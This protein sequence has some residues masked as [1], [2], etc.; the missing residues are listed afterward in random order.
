VNE[1][2]SI[3]RASS[4]LSHA[5][6]ASW[7]ATLVRVRGPAYRHVGARLL[8]ARE[9]VI[10]GSLSAG[11]IEAELVRTG[12]WH[13]AAGA[14]LRSFEAETPDDAEPKRM[15]S[16][17]GG[18]V[19]ALIEPNT[20]ACAE[21]LEFIQGAQANQESV[22]MATVIK[23][24]S[25]LGRLGAR[26]V[27]SANASVSSGSALELESELGMLTRLALAAPASKPRSLRRGAF[28]LLLEVL[29][30]APHLFVF[31]AGP[32]VV[33]VVAL[34]HHLGWQVTVVS[35]HDRPSA[36]ERFVKLCRYGVFSLESALS[37]LDRSARPLALV[38]SHDYEDDRDALGALLESRVRYLGVLGPL[39]RTQRLIY[40]LESAGCRHALGAI[41]R[42]HAPVGLSIGA[43]TP[44]EIA[45]SI[46]AE[47]QASLRG[48]SG[49]SL[50]DPL[51]ALAADRKSMPELRLLEVQAL[52]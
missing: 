38:M 17:C 50:G 28:E 32:D 24:G 47:A 5:G 41:T 40:D 19:D 42:V 25:K 39:Q 33:P 11:C 36:R 16:G 27:S 10:A 7:L 15:G 30:P 18:S 34:A 31:G 3:C 22:A 14:T 9:G 52:P 35:R 49:R 21:T 20:G 1:L 44:A 12:A 23:S 13:A 48:A 51:S 29:E 26:V 2:E 45:L 4:A 6:E 8:F 37:L 43:E 46:V